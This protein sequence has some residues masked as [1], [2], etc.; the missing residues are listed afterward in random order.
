MGVPLR[1]ALLLQEALTVRKGNTIIA[2]MTTGGCALLLALV[3]APRGAAAAPASSRQEALAARLHRIESAFRDDDAGALRASF[4]A[5]GK[6][7]LDLPEVPGCPASYGA[8]QLQ[9][10]FGQLFAD[11]RTRSFAFADD[12]GGNPEDTVFARARWAR[13]G[14]GA[15]SQALTFTLREEDGD[16]RIHEIVAAR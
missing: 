4:T 3:L 14:P 15:P 9:V 1:A 11:A 2:G 13:A 5:R 10:I 7:R 12:G 8:G 16:W 6:L